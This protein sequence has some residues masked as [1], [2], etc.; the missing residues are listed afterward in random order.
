[1][2]YLDHPFVVSTGSSRRPTPL[3][4]EHLRKWVDA[5]EHYVAL[6]SVADLADINTYLEQQATLYVSNVIQQ[7]IAQIVG[8]YNSD[9]ITIKSTE[10]GALH[11]YLA[12]SDLTIDVNS[13][14]A[15]GDDVALGA[16]ADA[17][18][19][20]GATGTLSAKLRRATQ[21]LEDLKSLIVL[22]AGTNL[23]GKVQIAGPPA[24]IQS[25]E[26]DIS[27]TSPND[28]IAVDGTKSHHICSIMFTVDAQTD[29]TLHDDGAVTSGPMDFGGTDEPRGMT[30]NFGI[31]PLVCGAGK[32]FQIT[33][34]AD[35]NV[36]G[37]ATYYSE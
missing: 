9:F 33:L 25:A 29:V 8:I 10:D 2:E 15:D 13:A 34:G 18:V 36:H 6:T 28:I 16:I 12:D 31:A 23:I 21:G 37:I 32:K 24:T 3:T 22:A 27:G 5:E 1:M 11:V 35:V 19:A 4:Y 20:A 17:I 7:V 14:I 26:I 30:H